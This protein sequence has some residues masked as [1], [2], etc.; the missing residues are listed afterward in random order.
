MAGALNIHKEQDIP[1]PDPDPDMEI[2]VED[3]T[4]SQTLHEVGIR[5]TDSEA[6]L[7]GA[8]EE[9]SQ[10]LVGL[11]IRPRKPCR[12]AGKSA[13]IALPEGYQSAP[14]TILCGEIVLHVPDIVCDDVEKMKRAYAVAK[15][16]L[17]TP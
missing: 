14:G 12:M 17:D 6:W 13:V 15:A 7:I 5:P 8:A 16:V 2:V 1:D 3:H 9:L 10:K 11:M 4:P